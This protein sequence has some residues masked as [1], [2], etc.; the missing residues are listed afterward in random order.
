MR[1]IIKIINNKT[2]LEIIV[3]ILLLVNAVLTLQQK[4]QRDFCLE[5]VTCL[6]H[7]INEEML[8]AWCDGNVTIFYTN[9]TLFNK[10]KS[11]NTNDV[12]KIS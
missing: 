12:F 5:H 6:Q 1:R 9:N 8:K 11:L 7:G 3:F 10:P 2:F 4:N